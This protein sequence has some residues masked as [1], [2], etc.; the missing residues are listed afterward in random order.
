MIITLENLSFTYSKNLDHCLKNLSLSFDT[1]QITGLAG[2]N[3]S[4]KTT[5]IRIL[6]G[7]LINFEGKY[8][9]D[10]EYI[11]EIYGNLSSR[12]GFGYAPETPRL[13]DAL[14]GYEI[15]NIV[16]D[17]RGMNEQD[18]KLELEQF[19]AHLHIDDWFRV[20]RCGEYSTGMRRKVALAI[21]FLGPIKFAILD[22]PTNG[23]DPITVFGLKKIIKA[24]LEAGTGTLLASHI[25]DFVEKTTDNIVLLKQG[26][27]LCHGQLGEV[28]KSNPDCTTL[29]EVYFK[30]FNT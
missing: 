11:S 27:L 17:I 14:T 13:D 6:L 22:E 10:Q 18:F 28:M 30:L 19:T 20:Q 25:L 15:L 16:A 24:K 1:T 9:V 2:A 29:E 4:G 12:V 23:L 26:E 7:Q 3:G 5:L 8:S 21:A